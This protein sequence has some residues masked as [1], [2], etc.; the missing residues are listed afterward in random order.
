MWRATH[1]WGSGKISPKYSRWTAHAKRLQESVKCP[2]FSFTDT[3]KCG[4]SDKESACQ[5]RRNKRR[6][7]NPWIRKSPWRRAWEPT[8]VFL[9]GESHGQRS[10]AVHQVTKSQTR[11]KPLSIHAPMTYHLLSTSAAH[12]PF[13][14]ILDSNS[15][16]VEPRGAPWESRLVLFAGPSAMKKKTYVWLIRPTLLTTR[17]KTEAGHRKPPAAGLDK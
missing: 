15:S 7:F 1:A 6:G 13:S 3:C 2:W 12:S 14:A 16:A 9:L 10:L 4:T 11:Q 5:R 8:P 17:K